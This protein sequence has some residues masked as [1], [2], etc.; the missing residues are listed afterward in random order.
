[1]KLTILYHDLIAFLYPNR[2]LFC[3]K[4]IA[5]DQS[6]CDDCGRRLIP[7]SAHPKLYAVGEIPQTDGLISVYRYNATS[8][9]AIFRLKFHGDRSVVKP[10]ASFM[11]RAVHQYYA[12]SR[13][14][15]TVIPVPM[16]RAHERK[17]GYNQSA[18]LARQIAE[19]LNLS[20]SD[21]LLYKIKRTKKQHDIS[22]RDRKSNLEGAFF[23]PDPAALHG[24]RILLVDDICTSGNTFY[25]CART[26]KEAG[27]AEA[28][29]V[30][31]LRQVSRYRAS[32]HLAEWE[33]KTY[34]VTKSDS[35]GF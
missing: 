34:R 5:P 23:A 22:H 21:R 14:P 25:Q 13:M 15:D 10:V 19:N 9:A 4:L 20:Y 1:M 8:K 32:Y 3:A 29:C 17:R 6:Y 27:A 28:V 2:C 30:S 11:S 33:P 31:F 26:L 24:R 16:H 12:A 18:L 7:C 35:E